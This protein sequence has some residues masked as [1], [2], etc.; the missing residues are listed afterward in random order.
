MEYNQPTYPYQPSQPMSGNQDPQPYLSY[1]QY[2]PQQPGF[3]QPPFPPTPPYPQ[4]KIVSMPMQYEDTTLESL[5]KM[6][7]G[8]VLTAYATYTNSKE[9]NDKIFK[10]VIESVGK[11]HFIISDP[12]S[13]KRFI[14]RYPSVNWIEFD[15]EIK[16]DFIR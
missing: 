10:G 6:N 1:Q 14:L 15:D 7:R 11:D 16:Y 9:F 8:K 13:G 3:S 12:K 5:L 4:T 2:T